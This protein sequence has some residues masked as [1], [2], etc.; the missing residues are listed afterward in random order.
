M[1]K[2]TVGIIVK[3][4]YDDLLY[5]KNNFFIKIEIGKKD[6]LRFT[7]EDKLSE[8]LDEKAFRI[9]KIS[10]KIP[11]LDLSNKYNNTENIVMYL[12]KVYMYS[13]NSKFLYKEDILDNLSTSL[14]KDDYV[15]YIIRYDKYRY[16]VESYIG[17]L[18]YLFWAIAIL[19]FPVEIRTK[20]LFDTFYNFWIAIIMYI[21]LPVFILYKFIV[22]SI[23]NYLVKYNISKKTIKVSRWLYGIA[24]IVFFIVLLKDIWIK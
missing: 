22:P 6:D 2:K 23:V 1:D 18:I 17:M 3:N 21:A 14:C 7:L 5:H 20:F 16:L 11:K 15:K 4:D 8:I 13:D 9:D 19:D 10:K 24:N 12:V